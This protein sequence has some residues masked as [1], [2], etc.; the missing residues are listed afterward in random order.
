MAE[1]N[2]FYQLVA[3][4]DTG[5]LSKA[6][7]IVH[8]SQPALTRSIQKLEAEWN[9][10]LFD[11]QKNKMTLNP[12][13]ELA[14]Q[15]ARRILDDVNSM[16]KA[17]QAYERSLRTISVGSCAPGPLLE[18]LPELTE[19]FY[20]MALTSEMSNPENLLSGLENGAYQLIITDKEVAAPDILCR[21][22]CMEQLY[23][24]VPPAHPLAVCRDGICLEDLAG[25]TMLLYKD[26]GIWKERVVS[27]MPQTKF[28][29]QDQGD[30]FS[31]LV[32]VS[33]LPAFV[34]DLTLKHGGGWQEQNRVT[35]PLL[36]PET[37]VTFYCSVHK[38]HKAYLPSQRSV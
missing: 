37:H 30:A 26:I 29:L 33:A 35:L 21:P 34:S 23:L 36:D 25:E 12:T 2:Q 18:L 7:E 22:F 17:V 11:R 8:I 14:V 15:Y 1:L 3:I 32:Q 10:T 38:S 24:T 4:A 6:A 28:I 9:V 5:T 16:T 19:R 13:G 31:A 27:K 20:G